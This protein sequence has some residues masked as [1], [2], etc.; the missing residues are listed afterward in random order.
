MWSVKFPFVTHS[1]SSVQTECTTKVL[2]N[3]M[4]FA[5]CSNATAEISI[6][7]CVTPEPILL[8]W[9][10][11]LYSG[12]STSLQPLWSI[13]T[14]HKTLLWLID[15]KNGLSRMRSCQFSF[16]PQQW[17]SSSFILWW[18][19]LNSARSHCIV[20]LLNFGTPWTTLSML[21]EQLTSLGVSHKFVG[22]LSACVKAMHAW[23]YS[24]IIA[25]M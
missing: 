4:W 14:T 17:L 19:T 22:M 25:W 8:K 2:D 11:H 21:W 10:S 18:R 24:R 5:S 13:Y 1:F 6:V 15:Y 16:R 23:P 12:T 20:H 9:S 7:Q 3:Q